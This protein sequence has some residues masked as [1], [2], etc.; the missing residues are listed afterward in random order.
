[1]SQAR[2][3]APEDHDVAC[4]HAI[5]RVVN[6]AFILGEAEREQFV[7][8][9]R[10]HEHFRGL[11]VPAYCVPGNHFH[12]LLAVPRP[13][14][15]LPGDAELLAR[16]KAVFS[17]QALGALRWKLDQWRRDGAR[18]EVEAP[19][20]RVCRRMWDLG[21]FM[22]GL[23]QRFGGWFN[24]RAGRR[25]TLWEERF[26]SVLVE[27]GEALAVI[28]A[29]IELNP[30]RAGI[31]A[32]PKDWR[33]SGYGAALGGVR[34]ARSGLR[35]V[36][37]LHRGREMEEKDALD[38]YRAFVFEAAG[39]RTAGS[40]GGGGRRGA[41]P[42]AVAEVKLAAGNLSRGELPRCRVRHFADGAALGSGKFVESVFKQERHRFG[43][44]RKTGARKVAGMG[45]MCSLRDL[46]KDTIKPPAP[47]PKA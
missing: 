10:C 3:K 13:P 11:R 4:C 8:M 36:M 32:D 37:R 22:K 18:A 46:K 17:P 14:A 24:R 47:S 7:E 25:G 43:K 34:K 40:N 12:L 30:V 2:L 26:K 42:A 45:G 39:E 31:V 1:M 5:S 33:W 19:G 41:K 15:A 28:A 38:A 16:A 44:G 6:R 29:Y 35:E 9:M 21:F 27:G 20:A 23:K